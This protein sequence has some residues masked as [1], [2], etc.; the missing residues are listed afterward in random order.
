[1]NKIKIIHNLEKWLPQTMPWLY[2]QLNN[3]PG[4][5]VE[6]IIV[7]EKKVFMEQFQLPNIYS[8]DNENCIQS[9]YRRV[10][11]RAGIKT[12]TTLLE[13][14]IEKEKPQIL[15]SH[16]GYFGWFNYRL[17]QKY[18]LKHVV[19]FYG[20]DVNK[21]PQ[22][23]IWKKRYLEM[24]QHIDLCLCE[25]P[26]MAECIKKLG[27]PPEKLKIQRIGINTEKI[28]FVPRIIKKDEP[29]HFFVASVFREK[30][31]IPFAIEAFR[32]LQK[33]TDNFR[34]TMIGDAGKTRPEEQKEKKRILEAIG[35][36][37]MES[38]ITQ[39]GF[40]SHS[41][42]IKEAYNSQIFVSP[43]IVS[44]DGDTEG[45]APVGIIEM[46]ASGMPVISTTHCDIPFVLGEPNK[47]LLVEERN[48]EQLVQAILKFLDYSEQE[49]NHLINA[50]REH[51]KKN[52]DVRS[53]AAELLKKY[54]E[55]L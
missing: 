36:F 27:C 16:F 37:N 18:R 51:I 33:H 8:L 23:K 55:L 17:A 14:I 22:K 31:G 35:K 2:E 11:R 10:I 38:K 25:G 34:V 48:P 28:K 7:C 39:L 47:K 44:S 4:E 3:M 54:K 15:H 45:G 50:N 6:N 53:C 24:F 52:M 26:Y 42:M 13:K 12:A 46:A 40:V 5:E 21:L 1:M 29:L 49:K 30:K 32:L 9:F 43:S 20:V 19:T 41:D